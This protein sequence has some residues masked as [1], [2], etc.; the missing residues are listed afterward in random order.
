M[1]YL[2]GWQGK[3]KRRFLDGIGLLFCCGSARS[4]MNIAMQ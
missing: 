3:G 2:S 4:K 1:A